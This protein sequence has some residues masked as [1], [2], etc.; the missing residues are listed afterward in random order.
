MRSKIA[1]VL[2]GGAFLLAGAMPAL[3]V[4]ADHQL[5][6]KVSH[7]DAKA[8]T[9]AVKEEGGTTAKVTSFTLAPDAKVMEGSKVRT[10]AE[11]KV[12]ER[13]MVTYTDQG[14]THQAKQIDMLPATAANVAP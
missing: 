1:A 8:K 13:I 10:F 7:L 12:G 3:A 11:L 2:A 5:S 9:V 4:T 14:S 6:G